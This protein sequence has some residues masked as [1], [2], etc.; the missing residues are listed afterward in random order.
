LDSRLQSQLSDI[1]HTDLL[2]PFKPLFSI[3]STSLKGF[4]DDSVRDGLKAAKWCLDHGLIQQ[5]F[6]I[7]NEVLVSHVLVR[8]LGKFEI[9]KEIRLLRLQYAAVEW[10]IDSSQPPDF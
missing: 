7:L 8:S 1:E 4:S 6:T 5:G 3:I 10:P 2:P 9:D